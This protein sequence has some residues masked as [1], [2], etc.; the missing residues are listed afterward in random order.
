[1]DEKQRLASASYV[2]YGPT[3]NNPLDEPRKVSH[4]KTHLNEGNNNV[5]SYASSHS[6]LESAIEASSLSSSRNLSNL[7]NVF[8]QSS[9]SGGADTV[10][11]VSSKS[12]FTNSSS[13]QWSVIN[14]KFG[15]G[16]SYIC[17]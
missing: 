13:K 3:T 1:V 17:N 5:I 10:P 9:G 8:R 11:E 14:S 16:N 15:I 2:N 6:S 12:N 7:F 4:D